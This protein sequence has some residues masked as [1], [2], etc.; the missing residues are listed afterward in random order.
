MYI[1]S[2]QSG[3]GDIVADGIEATQRALF[4]AR[5]SKLYIVAARSTPRQILASVHVATHSPKRK[6]L[7]MRPGGTTEGLLSRS[8]AIFGAAGA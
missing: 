1:A 6:I 4:I 3:R 2:R 8:T 5:R 7:M